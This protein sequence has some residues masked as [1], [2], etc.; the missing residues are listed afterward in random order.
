MINNI[1]YFAQ[2]FELG[3]IHFSY[4]G[5]GRVDEGWGGEGLMKEG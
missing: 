1:F 2:I 3:T 5:R 4:L